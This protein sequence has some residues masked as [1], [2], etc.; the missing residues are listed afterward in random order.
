MSHNDV[1]RNRSAF[2]NVVSAVILSSVLLSIMISASFLSKDILATQLA[3]SE[4]KIAEN[5]MVT[6]DSEINKLLFKQGTSS[7][8]KTSFSTAAPGFVLTGETMNVTIEGLDEG[9]EKE[10][11]YATELNTFKIEGRQSI[12]GSFEYD[13]GGGPSLLVS[14]YNGNLGRI[15]ISKPRNLRVSLDYARVRYTFTG[16]I[17]LFNGSHYVP[18]NT[19]ELTCVALSFGAFN[20][21]G[22]SIILIQNEKIMPE[23][24]ELEGN[25]NITVSTLG[26]SETVHLSDIGGDPTYPTVVNYHRIYIKI[27]VME[28]W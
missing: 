23:T 28:G 27:S 14:P 13:L 5:I 8:I 10:Y 19:L 26:G 6:I 25:C 20:V 9:L 16:I 12:T 21:M 3:A 22:N 2:S 4:F 1:I 15:H 11:Q 7:V 17:N 24:F 18:H